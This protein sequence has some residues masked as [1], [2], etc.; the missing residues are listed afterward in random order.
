MSAVEGP[1]PAALQAPLGGKA[2]KCDEFV[3]RAMQEMGN[4]N[5]CASVG[6]LVVER[7]AACQAAGC[8]ASMGVAGVLEGLAVCCPCYLVAQLWPP[9]PGS[10]TSPQTTYMQMSVSSP[11]CQ[12]LRR[13]EAPRPGGP[14]PSLPARRANWP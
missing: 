13:W 4:I 8:G 2:A 11:A 12:P 6:R 1:L 5:I 7:R 3:N 9:L 14:L 10:S